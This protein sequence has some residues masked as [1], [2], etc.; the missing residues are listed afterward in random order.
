MV[1][2]FFVVFG[3]F[4]WFL[5]FLFSPLPKILIYVPVV[6][7]KELHAPA[8]FVKENVDKMVLHHVMLFCGW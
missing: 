3:F 8:S 1:F 6:Q 4:L 7:T 2:G 5:V